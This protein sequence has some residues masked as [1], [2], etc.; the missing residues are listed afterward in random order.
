MPAQLVDCHSWLEELIHKRNLPADHSY[1]ALF[2]AVD[3]DG[4]GFV[5]YDELLDVVRRE[6]Q[7][8]RSVISDDTLKALWCAL[9][10]DSSNQ[11]QVCVDFTLTPSHLPSPSS[12]PSHAPSA[13]PP[14]P[15]PQPHPHP[16]ADEFAKWIKRGM[17]EGTKAIWGEREHLSSYTPASLP[18]SGMRGSIFP[19]T[20]PPPS[21]PSIP[22]HCAPCQH[23]R[24][25][26]SPSHCLISPSHFLPTY[27][28]KHLLIYPSLPPCLAFRPSR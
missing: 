1:F 9:D 5:T 8:G 3:A 12:S 24:R 16:K 15:Q 13:S 22:S 26:I 18:A 14:H 21:L 4:S 25:L 27:E 28:E 2:K 11:L 7:V 19:P 17:K 10:V 20:P 6:L 23:T